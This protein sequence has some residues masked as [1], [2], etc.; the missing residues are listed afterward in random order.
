LIGPLEHFQ[1]DTFIARWTDRKLLADA[2][3]SFSLNPQGKVE[4]IRMQAVPRQRIFPT[5]STISISGG[6]SRLL[7][8]ESSG[9]CPA[10]A[11]C[12][13]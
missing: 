4:R 2:C 6:L 13:S 12:R 11:R 9:H 8:T 1:Y 10:A 5:T 3:V 7:A